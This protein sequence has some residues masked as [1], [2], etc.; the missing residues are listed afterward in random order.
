MKQ[1]AFEAWTVFT[2]EGPR[3]MRLCGLFSFLL[4]SELVPA[5]PEAFKS[6]GWPH[7]CTASDVPLVAIKITCNSTSE[8]KVLPTESFRSVPPTHS[9][10]KN[11]LACL[12]RA[13]HREAVGMI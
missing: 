13:G 8:C 12:I 7:E 3:S 5:L 6:D 1:K 10:I 2:Q 4:G 11:D 9:L